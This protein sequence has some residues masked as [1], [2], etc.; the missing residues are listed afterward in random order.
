LQDHVLFL[1]ESLGGVLFGV[2]PP[3]PFGD[4]SSGIAVS[5]EWY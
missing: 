1:G 4:L 2:M 3:A 5:R